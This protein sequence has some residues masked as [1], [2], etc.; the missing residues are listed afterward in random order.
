MP[1]CF[2]NMFALEGLLAFSVTCFLVIGILLQDNIQVEQRSLDGNE[3]AE[4][5][6]KNE[7]DQIVERSSSLPLVSHTLAAQ[8]LQ[9]RCYL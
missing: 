5:H 2:S 6:E 3:L 8:S 4:K 7:K 1:I 9:H